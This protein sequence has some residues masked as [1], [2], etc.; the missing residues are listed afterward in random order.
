MIKCPLSL[1]AVTTRLDTLQSVLVKGEII[2]EIQRSK[3]IHPEV[4]LES[5]S[6]GGLSTLL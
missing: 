3:I 6:S 4:S 5:L 1:F 2:E